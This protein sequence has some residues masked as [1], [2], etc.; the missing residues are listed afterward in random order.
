MVLRGQGISASDCGCQG[1]EAQESGET[2]LLFSSPGVCAPPLLRH[3]IG[4]AIFAIKFI[5]GP[6]FQRQL[7]DRS[8]RQGKDNRNGMTLVFAC[9]RVW[10]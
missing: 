4:P 1:G 9:C 6:F 2:V 8:F 5:H 7:F 3:F 10:Q